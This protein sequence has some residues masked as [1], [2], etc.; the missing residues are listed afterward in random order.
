MTAQN[1]TTFAFEGDR[2]VSL[3]NRLFGK[4]S[5][6]YRKSGRPAK[7]ISRRALKLERLE[8]RRVM[9]GVGLHA[10]IMP[11]HPVK[12]MD[13]PAGTMVGIIA[14]PNGQ[15]AGIEKLA[16]DGKEIVV[17]NGQQ[18]G[19]QQFDSVTDLTFSADGT[20]LGY[21]GSNAVVV[22]SGDITYSDYTST[23]FINGNQVS[24]RAVRKDK[25]TRRRSRTSSS[26]PIA[27]I[28]PPW[29][30]AALGLAAL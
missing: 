28:G 18:V 21:V 19:R 6:G 14:G 12:P 26:A 8:E 29:S 20:K 27:S 2:I 10:A 1:K 25:A 4:E 24:L 30:A 23:V 22:S 13:L 11:H 5:A 9:S 16:G 17:E 3:L 15:L 7:K